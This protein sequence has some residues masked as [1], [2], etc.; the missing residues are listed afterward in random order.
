[1]VCPSLILHRTVP[2]SSELQ[3]QAEKSKTR[4]GKMRSLPMR[5]TV[6][7][8]PERARNNHDDTSEIC[9]SGASGQFYPSGIQERY[10]NG[11]S[12]RRKDQSGKGT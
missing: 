11:S 12:D 9:A 5:E 3:K 1:M 4:S 6:R 2:V 8:F 7:N 10:Q